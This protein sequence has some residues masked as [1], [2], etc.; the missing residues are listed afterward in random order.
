MQSTFS[1]IR[2]LDSHLTSAALSFLVRSSA[3]QPMHNMPS[4][5]GL[6]HQ[7]QTHLELIHV[8][9]RLLHHPQRP[10]PKHLE[11]RCLAGRT[12]HDGHVKVRSLE[13]KRCLVALSYRASCN[14]TL[15]L[16][17]ADLNMRAKMVFDSGC[18]SEHSR[19]AH[20]NRKC[21]HACAK[22]NLDMIEKVCQFGEFLSLDCAARSL[23]R[24]APWVNLRC[25]ILSGCS[26]LLCSGYHF[27]HT[28][29][30]TL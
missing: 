14:M 12:C 30:L 25:I 10:P 21:G 4:W 15:F 11:S 28:E 18:L 16:D 7:F 22:A 8:K 17:P 29:A 6:S 9:V 5:F 19:I 24:K 27:R 2:G 13:A 26:A 3:I 23:L 20:Q 1:H